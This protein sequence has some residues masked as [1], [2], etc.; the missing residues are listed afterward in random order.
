M[1]TY[2]KAAFASDIKKLGG[3]HFGKRLLNKVSEG[4]R[5]VMCLSKERAARQGYGKRRGT[6]EVVS[7]GYRSLD[8]I[9]CAV[10]VLRGHCKI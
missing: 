3:H 2:S 1:R 8:F 10:C 7:G 5:R 4:R 6:L 9:L